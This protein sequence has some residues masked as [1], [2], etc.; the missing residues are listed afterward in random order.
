M[1]A[2]SLGVDQPFIC[3]KVWNREIP[4]ENLGRGVPTGR[5]GGYRPPPF[6]VLVDFF[7]TQELC[8]PPRNSKRF[9][10]GE[11]EKIGGGKSGGVEGFLL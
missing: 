1:G 7:A 4:A 8:G 5:A 6:F 11:V 3:Y 2:G 9:P 10:R